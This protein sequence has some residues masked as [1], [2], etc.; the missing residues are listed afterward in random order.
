[1]EA[2][3]VVGGYKGWSGGGEM[4]IR[5]VISVPITQRLEEKEIEVEA[6]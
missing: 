1:M 2:I 6:P 3:K 4:A 5:T